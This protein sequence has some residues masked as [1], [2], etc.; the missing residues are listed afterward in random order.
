MQ[1]DQRS[2]RHSARKLHRPSYF[3]FRRCCICVHLEQ[4]SPGSRSAR[5]HRPDL[6]LVQNDLG[7]IFVNTIRRAQPRRSHKEIRHAQLHHLPRGR[8]AFQIAEAAY[9]RALRS[10]ARSISGEVE[11][12]CQLSNGGTELFRKPFEAGQIHGART[13]AEWLGALGRLSRN[14][15]DQAWVAT[16]NRRPGS[17]IDLR[18]ELA[19]L[20]QAPFSRPRPSIATAGPPGRLR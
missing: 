17:C 15:D 2:I 19:G 7:W 3:C 6:C 20:A 18:V 8:K 9:R 13:Q 12:A 1:H 16:S 5:F 11:P 10:F 14:V 4:S